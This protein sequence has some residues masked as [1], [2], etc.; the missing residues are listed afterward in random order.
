MRN[1]KYKNKYRIESARL[2]N[3]DYRKNGSYFITICTKNREHFFGEIEN[4]EMNLSKTGIIADVLWY[5]I[6]N[7]LPNISLGEFVIM[8]NHIHGIIEIQGGKTPPLQEKQPTLG[9]IIGYFKY[10]TTKYINEIDGTYGKKTWQRNYF[11]QIIR[12][13]NDLL[14]ICEYIKTNPQNWFNDKENPN[15]NKYCSGEI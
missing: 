1:N 15:K 4:D 10:Q 3:Y 2:K 5:E 9:Q 14:K 13:E 8:P 11:E 12:T 6:A 7:R